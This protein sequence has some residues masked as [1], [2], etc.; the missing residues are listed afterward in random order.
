MIPVLLYRMIRNKSQTANNVSA[1]Y[2]KIV[3]VFEDLDLYLNRLKILEKR[4]RTVPE[5]DVAL[6]QVLASVLVLC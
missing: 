5:L 1:D 2:D 6:A 4:V 3:E